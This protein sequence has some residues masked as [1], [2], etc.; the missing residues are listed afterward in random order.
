MATSVTTVVI[1]GAWGR[2]G[3]GVARAAGAEGATPATRRVSGCRVS[4]RRDGA[5]PD[6]PPD[7]A[8]GSQ[9]LARHS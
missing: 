3:K 7:G 8:A 2:I 5:I 4:G 6:T 1:M 9:C